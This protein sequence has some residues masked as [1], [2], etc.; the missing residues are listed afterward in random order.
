VTQRP[1][2]T[3][4]PDD[5]C[6]SMRAGIFTLRA[7]RGRERVDGWWAEIVVAGGFAEWIVARKPTREVGPTLTR[8][9]ARAVALAMR[10]AVCAEA[11]AVVGVATREPSSGPPRPD[12]GPGKMDRLTKR[13]AQVLAYM[14]GQQVGRGYPPTIREIAQHIGSKSPFWPAQVLERL[15]AKGYAERRAS[16]ARCV[17]AVLDAAGQKVFSPWAE[18]GGD[19]PEP[20]HSATVDPVSAR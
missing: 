10:D 9:E 14:I 15:T 8:S 18:P 1:G 17:V 6:D 2:W 5:H 11:L 20:P 13:E 12:Q 3:R 16:G 19:A 4:D 7:R